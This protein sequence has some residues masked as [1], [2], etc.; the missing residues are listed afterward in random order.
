VKYGSGT[1]LAG[2]DIGNFARESV[3]NGLI[4]REEDLVCSLNLIAFSVP[5]WF[6][7]AIMG[8]DRFIPYNIT[9]ITANKCK[10]AF[11]NSLAE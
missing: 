8:N 7:M 11:R 10:C 6:F 3:A 2:K 5:A 1:Q 4:I 9:V